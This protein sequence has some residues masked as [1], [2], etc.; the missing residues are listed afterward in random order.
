MDGKLVVCSGSLYYLICLSV[1][2]V[3]RSVV[4]EPQVAMVAGWLATLRS[5]YG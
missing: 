5:K 4:R 1:F 3:K 2:A